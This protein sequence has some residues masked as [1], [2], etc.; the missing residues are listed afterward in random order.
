MLNFIR[1]PGLHMNIRFREKMCGRMITRSK[2]DKLIYEEVETYFDRGIYE[3]E[4]TLKRIHRKNRGSSK[5]S[6]K[7]RD[8]GRAV[9][10]SQSIIVAYDT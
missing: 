5:S 2:N 1:T 4:E 3:C 9:S 7:Y 8:G 10:T 6:W